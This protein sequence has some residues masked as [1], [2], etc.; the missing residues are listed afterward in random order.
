MLS[1][2]IQIIGALVT[3]RMVYEYSK[4]EANLIYIQNENQQ[5]IV[6]SDDPNILD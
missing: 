2:V 3:I 1:I 6:L 4:V 5:T